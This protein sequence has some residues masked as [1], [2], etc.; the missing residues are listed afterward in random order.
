MP[1]SCRV[2]ENKRLNSVCPWRIKITELSYVGESKKE[3]LNSYERERQL[4]CA[5]AVDVGNQLALF[6][7]APHVVE[8]T[9]WVS[10]K[11][12]GAA[13]GRGRKWATFSNTSMS[14]SS[15]WLRHSWFYACAACSGDARETSVAATCSYDESSR[16]PIRAHRQQNRRTGRPTRQSLPHRAARLP[17]A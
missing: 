11:I 10:A 16:R 2:T 1:G 8:D 7:R 13:A 4:R 5:T 9:G 15:Q 17:R 12:L 14:S 6:A 3:N